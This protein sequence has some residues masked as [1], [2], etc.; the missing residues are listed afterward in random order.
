MEYLLKSTFV[1]SLFYFFYILFLQKDTF[2]QSIRFYFI[3]GIVASLTI[4]IIVIKKYVLIDPVIISGANITVGQ[5]NTIPESTFSWSQIIWLSYFAGVLFFTV[6]FLIQLSSLMWFLYENP[7]TKKGDFT[8]VEIQKDITPFSFFNYIA[9]NKNQFQETELTQIIAHEKTHATQ[10]HSIDILLIQLFAIFHWFNPFV[11]LYT[12]E[13]QKNLEF[14]ADGHALGTA[15]DNKDYHHLLLKTISPN[16]QMTLTTN[17]YNSLIKKRIDMLQKNRSSKTMQIKFLLVIP[18]LIAFVFTFNTK[19]IAQ[20]KDE[21]KIE[22]KTDRVDYFEVITKDTKNHEL[23]KMKENFAKSGTKFKFKKLKRNNKDEITG[24]SI[25]VKN[26]A[27]N[28]AKLSQQSDKPISAIKIN[29]NLTTGELS[30]GNVSEMDNTQNVFFSSGSD[31]THQTYVVK[32]DKKSD[33]NMT[34]VTADDT[35]LSLVEESNGV[36][37]VTNEDGEHK[38]ITVTVDENKDIQFGDSGKKNVSVWVS[39]E[40]D[41][42]TLSMGEDKK[43]SYTYTIKRVGGEDDIHVGHDVGSESSKN[44]IFISDGKTKGDSTKLGEIKIIKLHEDGDEPHKMIIKTDKSSNGNTFIFKTD[45]DDKIDASNTKKII[46][47]S[48]SNKTPLFILDG[49]E[50]KEGKIDDISP[51]TIQSMNVLKG[52]KAIEKYG[53][54]GKDGVIEITT[55]K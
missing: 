22:I 25:T 7:K 29:D 9:I 10:Y 38:T 30:I 28:E 8:F 41:T 21:W 49:K 45:S 20:K 3:T 51:D 37:I 2:F 31:G 39:D 44:F 32:S 12:K 34:W 55:K 18:M 4:P 27:G 15:S 42:S 1:L 6:K 47:R 43:K 53:E 36:V 50:M 14:I 23:E 35:K 24:I 13:I 48:N 33:S 19:V 26:K 16:Y 17:F 11:W 5:I 46:F 40:N 54:K 52:E